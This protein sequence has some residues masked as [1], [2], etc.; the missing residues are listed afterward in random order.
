MCEGCHI[1]LVSVLAVG[2]RNSEVQI[3]HSKM[4][5]LLFV[6]SRLDEWWLNNL[7]DDPEERDRQ[8]WEHLAKMQKRREE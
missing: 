2:G 6:Q 3:D 7:H 4:W 8:R 5:C 1:W